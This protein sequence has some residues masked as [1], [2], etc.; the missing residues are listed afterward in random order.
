MTFLTH[1][2]DATIQRLV[3]GSLSEAEASAAKRHIEDCARCRRSS[4]EVSALFTA[5]SAAASRPEPRADFLELVMSR[6]DREPGL[7]LQPIRPRVVVGVVAAG[8]ATAVA[9]GLM[10]NAGGGEIVPVAELVTGF[11][12]V[13]MHAGTLGA[14]AKALAPIAGG[15]ALAST[16][17]LAPF[18]IRALRSVQPKAT[19]ARVVS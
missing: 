15:A 8:V 5:L 11:M 13:A 6:V 12:S 17:V 7:V 16:V 4:G 2:E 19:R 14:L 10:I 3:E 18:F 1:L 9:G